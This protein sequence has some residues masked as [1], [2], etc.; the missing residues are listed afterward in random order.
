VGWRCRRDTR[1]A[2][3]DAFPDPDAKMK[4]LDSW[5]DAVLARFGNPTRV[6]KEQLDAR[7]VRVWLSSGCLAELAEVARAAAARGRQV[8]ESYVACLLR[9]MQTLT[10]FIQ[11]WAGSDK[12]IDLSK[13]GE[14][15]AIARKYAVPRPWIVNEPHASVREHTNVTHIQTERPIKIVRR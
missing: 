2:R 11:E 5:I 7:G 10:G 6:L 9:E 8:D 3:S 12:E 4:L 13:W 14:F 15:V 1:A